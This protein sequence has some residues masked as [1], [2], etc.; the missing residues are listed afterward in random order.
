MPWHI[1]QVVDNA[2]KQCMPPSEEA[3]HEQRQTRRTNQ[4]QQRWDVHL[5][6]MPALEIGVTL[7]NQRRAN[8]SAASPKWANLSI[9]EPLH[10]IWACLM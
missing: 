2:Q 10:Q 6:P 7:A 9:S 3:L 4:A 8:C 1:P 5:I